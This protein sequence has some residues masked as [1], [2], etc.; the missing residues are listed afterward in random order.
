VH[1]T[2]KSESAL[3]QAQLQGPG[4]GQGQAQGAGGAE[5]GKGIRLWPRTRS[6]QPQEPDLPP[7]T[8][9]PPAA[10]GACLSGLQRRSAALGRWAE[11]TLWPSALTLEPKS[12]AWETPAATL[13][14]TQQV[15]RKVQGQNWG[16]IRGR[17]RGWGWGRGRGGIWAVQHS[18]DRSHS[19]DAAPLCALEAGHGLT[20]PLLHPGA[21]RRAQLGELSHTMLSL[22][23]CAE[24]PYCCS[25]RGPSPAALKHKNRGQTCADPGTCDWRPVT[26]DL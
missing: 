5:R 12:P 25:Q 16:D 4:Q 18:E 14:P 24:A 15:V 2:D 19:A 22:P 23:R 21:G 3:G 9:E 7:P 11:G 8:L 13:L 1:A 10:A 17:S 6:Q 26:C 20:P